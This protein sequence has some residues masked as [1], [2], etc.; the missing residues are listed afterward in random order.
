M[1]NAFELEQDAELQSK[2]DPSRGVS[3]YRGMHLFVLCHGFHGS[4]FDVRTF[5]NVIS[6][7]LPDALFLCAE[8]NE[9]DSDLDIFDMGYKLSEEVH[10][11]IRENCPGK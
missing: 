10:A 1:A 5:K 7:A 6:I 8:S 9:K 2:A 3:N 11:Y 4:S